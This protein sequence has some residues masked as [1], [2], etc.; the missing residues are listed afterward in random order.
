MSWKQTKQ[1]I[2][3]VTAVPKINTV[4][5]LQA[6]KSENVIKFRSYDLATKT[7]TIEVEPIKGVYVGHYF[8]VECYYS[9]FQCSANTTAYF[10]KTD[11]V[12]IFCTD[13]QSQLNDHIKA[14]RG[15]AEDSKLLLNSLKD[16]QNDNVKT[17]AVVIV[18]TEKGVIEVKTNP[19]IFLSQLNKFE[20]HSG[21]YMIEINPMLWNPSLGIDGLPKNYEKLTESMYPLFCD[22]KLTQNNITPIHEKS[23]ELDSVFDS[24]KEFKEFIKKDGASKIPEVQTAYVPP[25]RQL[26]ATPAPMGATP[27]FPDPI[28]GD[29]L[30]F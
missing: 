19:S 12:R 29:D 22:M 25:V 24:F 6:K 28:E 2:N 30:P 17:F 4:R 13:R 14:F 16:N 23:F 18:A 27:S 21:D 10:A 11:R 26:P 8:K 1:E 7:E 9:A 20:K 5:V 15:S 3:G